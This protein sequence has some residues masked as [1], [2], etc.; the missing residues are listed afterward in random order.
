MSL[1]LSG[2]GE[3]GLVLSEENG[4]IIRRKKQELNGGK[5][6]SLNPDFPSIS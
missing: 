3:L 2:W 6:I 4:N 1:F 5:S